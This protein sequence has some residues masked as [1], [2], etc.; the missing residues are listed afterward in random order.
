MYST[1]SCQIL[2][3]LVLCQRIWKNLQIPNIVKICP[4][5]AKLFHMDGWMDRKTTDGKTDM[6]KLTGAL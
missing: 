4:V 3:K 2:I 5:G 6:T 1:H